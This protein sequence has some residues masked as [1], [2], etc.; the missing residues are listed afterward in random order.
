MIYTLEAAPENSN[1]NE[2]RFKIQLTGACYHQSV[3]IDKAIPQ[4]IADS[5]EKSLEF[6]N[7]EIICQ[8]LKKYPLVYVYYFLG[9]SPD[10][11]SKAKLEFQLQLRNLTVAPVI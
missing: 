2:F 1:C 8:P 7:S 10:D 3:V 6:V 9:L 4:G 11:L 5:I